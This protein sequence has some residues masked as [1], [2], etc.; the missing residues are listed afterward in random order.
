MLCGASFSYADLTLGPKPNK[1]G[2]LGIEIVAS[3][4]PD[5]IKEWISTPP[6]HQVMINRLKE[7]GPEQL[8][9]TAFLV[10]GMSS[11]SSGNFE[12]SVSFYLLGPDKKPIF[13]QGNYAIGEGKHPDKPTFIM[14]DPALDLILEHSDPE[15]TY[16]IVAQ[17]TD[18]MNG[19]KADSFYEIR[20]IKDKP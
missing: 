15:G 7:V 13:G 19:K 3:K 9:V 2:D 5:Y 1:A 17:V 20:Y 8:I 14:A 18:R 11:D 6:K 4:T 16:T 10:T 12:F